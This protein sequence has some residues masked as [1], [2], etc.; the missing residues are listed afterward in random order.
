MH[1]RLRP[2]EG[3]AEVG[4]PLRV[5]GRRQNLL[6]GAVFDNVGNT[7]S[8]WSGAWVPTLSKG[9]PTGNA[10]GRGRVGCQ[11]RA[12]TG[13]STAAPR[14]GVPGTSF[15]GRRATRCGR[16]RALETMY[17]ATSGSALGRGRV[18]EMR[19]LRT[20]TARLGVDD[21]D[22]EERVGGGSASPCLR[23]WSGRL[24]TI[25]VQGKPNGVMNGI[26]I[27]RFRPSIASFWSIALYRDASTT[28][29]GRRAKLSASGDHGLK[30]RV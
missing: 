5:A 20:G 26:S 8:G 4:C 6:R 9:A 27:P 13:R 11:P 14:A 29:A 16:R 15:R 21:D 17:R 1:R 12:A 7:V 19:A 22:D 23:G 10:T 25:G 28:G 18:E 3:R 30:Y 2:P 24:T